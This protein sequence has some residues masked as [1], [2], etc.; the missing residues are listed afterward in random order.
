MT[1]FGLQHDYTSSVRPYVSIRLVE[2][3][4]LG[5]LALVFKKKG[6]PEEFLYA[7]WHDVVLGQ[8]F[9]SSQAGNAHFYSLYGVTLFWTLGT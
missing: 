2:C 9:S 8:C 1:H 6:R 7:L 5:Q 3:R 4:R